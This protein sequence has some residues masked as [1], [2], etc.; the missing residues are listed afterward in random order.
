VGAIEAKDKGRL[1]KLYALTEAIPQARRG[2]ISA[3]GWVSAQHL[4]GIV[5][6]LLGSADAFRRLIAIAACTMQRVDPGT[7]LAEAVSDSE[8]ALRARALRAAGELGRR[9]LL[10]ACVAALKEENNEARIW[11][12]QSAVLLGRNQQGVKALAGIAVAPSP[13]RVPALRLPLKVVDQAYAKELLRRLASDPD[14][15]RLLILGS[16]F[17]GDPAYLPWLIQQMDDPK[18]SRPAGEAFALVTGLDLPYL[19]L[20]RTPTADLESGPTPKTPRTRTSQWTRMRA[21]DGRTRQ[22]SSS[23]GPQTAP[24]S[25]LVPSETF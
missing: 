1:E 16:G 6:G 21:F 19:D 3:F 9:D 12:A 13:F 23:G 25:A 24:A 5:S 15:R 22:R 10:P 4:E 18:L 7:G 14:D 11:S 20:E 2:L 8:P 17:A